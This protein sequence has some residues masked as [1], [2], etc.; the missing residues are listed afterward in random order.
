M[1]ANESG[2]LND[3][4]D[5]E[6]AHRDFLR[7]ALGDKGIGN[8]KV[9]FS[10]VNFSNRRSVLTTARTFEDLGVSAYNGAGKLLKSSDYLAAA[11]KIV[12]VEARHAATI[13]HMLQPLSEAF[14]GS[15]VV[16]GN[17]LDK[18]RSPSA[19]LK[20]VKPFIKT[21]VTMSSL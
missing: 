1:S 13:R 21:P 14:S 3:I 7:E 4:R 19:V 17:G 6:V 15:D 5:H 8:L 18:A 16:D 2:I 12:S 20:A 9:D 10:V 11:G